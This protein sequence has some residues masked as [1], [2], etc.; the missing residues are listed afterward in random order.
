MANEKE[1]WKYLKSKKI[2][3]AGC[4]AI[5]GNMQAESG[6]IANKVENL[7]LQRLREHDRVYTDETYTA[8]VD[9]GAIT[10]EEFLNPIIYRQYGYGLCQWTY[11]TRKKGLYNTCKQNKA[12]IGDWKSQCQ[13]LIKELKTLFPKLWTL[14]QN[15]KS[16]DEAT[17]EF[18]IEFERPANAEG[19]K[20]LRR[21]YAQ[22]WYDKYA[23]TNAAENKSKSKKSSKKQ[24]KTEEAP[25]VTTTTTTVS[26]RDKVVSIAKSLIGIKESDGS[27]RKIIDGYNSIKPLPGGYKMQY[28][29]PWCATFVS[30][31]AKEAGALDVIPANCGCPQMIE[32][33]K[34]L[35]SWVESDSYTPKPGDIIFYDWQDNA[36]YATTDNT[37]VSDHVGIVEAVSGN[38]FSVIEG[39]KNDAVERRGMAINGKFIRGYGVPKYRDVTVTTTSTSAG[40]YRV[41]AASFRLESEAQNLVD[42]LARV[43]IDSYFYKKNDWY[44]VQAG[45]FASKELADNRLAALKELGITGMIW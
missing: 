29:D 38:Q 11:P 7:C 45:S 27:H 3:D 28:T 26:Q 5:L 15:S 16:V 37:G 4:A 19:M 41:Q 18:L 12:S 39:N 35:G 20:T 9:S 34:K 6:I 13:Y 17:D 23:E 21:S 8:A 14:L 44:L 25:K 33:F 24:E 36:N 42:M 10:L 32:D 22:K 31:V 40:E 30:Y 2:T 1:I 43:G